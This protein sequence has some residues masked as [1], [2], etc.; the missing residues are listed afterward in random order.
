MKV[1]L[2]ETIESLGNV[3][4]EVDVAKGYARNY[5]LPRKKVVLATEANR[6][7]I[8]RERAKLE[9]KAAE[10]RSLAEAEALKIKDTVCTVA[11]KVSE[12]DRLYGS[13]TARDIVKALQDKG[14]EVEKKMVLLEEPI[15]TLGTY[16]VAIQFHPDIKPE[17][18][19]E[20]VA[21]QEI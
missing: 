11:A 12:E 15:K 4:D 14:F 5:L 2:R 8:E 6:R 21:E 3:G 20:V 17:I 1:I 9:L 7:V 10:E 18:T 19:V 16:T 13:V